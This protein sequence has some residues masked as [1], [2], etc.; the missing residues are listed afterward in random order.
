MMRYVPMPRNKDKQPDLHILDDTVVTG[1]LDYLHR[2]KYSMSLMHQPISVTCVFIVAVKQIYDVGIL[3]K[4]NTE[5]QSFC[6]PTMSE[7]DNTK[8]RII[9]AI[10]SQAFISTYNSHNKFKKILN[11]THEK[12]DAIKLDKETIKSHHM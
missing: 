8:F 3:G 5:H 7:L 12:A 4:I 11:N 2:P 9:I 10:L 6:L 1:E